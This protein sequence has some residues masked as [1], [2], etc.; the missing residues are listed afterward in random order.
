M[1]SIIILQRMLH[2]C[3]YMQASVS[4]DTS[5]RSRANGDYLMIHLFNSV[6]NIRS[7]SKKYFDY[8]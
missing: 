2:N 5:K 8:F 3:L 4:A 7:Y 6:A 1:H